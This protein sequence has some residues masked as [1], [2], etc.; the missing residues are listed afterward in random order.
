MGRAQSCSRTTHAGGNPPASAVSLPDRRRKCNRPSVSWQNKAP[1]SGSFFGQSAL[2]WVKDADRKMCLTLE[3]LKNSKPAR[4]V[5]LCRCAVARG[6]ICGKSLYAAGVRFLSPGSRSAPWV[7]E[8]TPND[9]P[10]GFHKWLAD[11]DSGLWNPVGVPSF[12]R[13]VTQGALRDPGLG[14]TTLSG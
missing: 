9:T 2:T 12:F 13:A 4:L 8:A 10:K 14:N 5:L 11:N 3:P 7:G 1:G 6:W